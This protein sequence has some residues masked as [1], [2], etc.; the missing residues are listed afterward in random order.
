MERGSV[1]P[2]AIF[3]EFELLCLFLFVDGCCVVAAF[4][5]CAGESDYICH[6]RLLPFMNVRTGSILAQQEFFTV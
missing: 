4:A 1:A 2:L 5:L 3:L 6:V